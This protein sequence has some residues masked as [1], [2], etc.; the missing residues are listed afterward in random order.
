MAI[1]LSNLHSINQVDTAH[2]LEDIDPITNY[3][4]VNIP[5]SDSIIDFNII[6][7]SIFTLAFGSSNSS[8]GACGG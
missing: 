1:K 5:T 4:G 3:G 7:I 6:L 8:C 2:R